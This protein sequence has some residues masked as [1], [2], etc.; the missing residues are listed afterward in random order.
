MTH[1]LST[2]P[3][4]QCKPQFIKLKLIDIPFINITVL[5]IQE[6]RKKK[7]YNKIKILIIIART[8]TVLP[9]R[10]CTAAD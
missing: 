2:L 5:L 6:I 10:L 1:S 8:V 9:I 4:I 3:P 7:K